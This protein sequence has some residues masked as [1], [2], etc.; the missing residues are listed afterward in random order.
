MKVLVDLNLKF[1][2]VINMMKSFWD[3][4]EKKGLTRQEIES[5][6]WGTVVTEEHQVLKNHFQYVFKQ[7][8]GVLEAQKKKENEVF[9]SANIVELKEYK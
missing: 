2:E 4:M 6:D 3:E 7:C 9:L 8:E 5:I 1:Y